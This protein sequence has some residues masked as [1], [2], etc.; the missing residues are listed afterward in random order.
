MESKVILNERGV[1]LNN[2][3][4]SILNNAIHKDLADSLIKAFD[5]EISKKLSDN[6]VSL[7]SFDDYLRTN[8]DYVLSEKEVEDMKNKSVI[9]LYDKE[10]MD[11]GYEKFLL[12]YDNKKD[13]ILI[14]RIIRLNVSY[15]ENF[16]GIERL[17]NKGDYK[18][19]FIPLKTLKLDERLN[20]FFKTFVEGRLKKISNEIE[21]EIKNGKKAFLKSN[22]KGVTFSNSFKEEENRI[23]ITLTIDRKSLKSISGHINRMG[24]FLEICNEV[25]ERFI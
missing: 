25:E 14:K 4:L 21:N 16:F 12:F 22:S 8:K 15:Y 7:S 1:A 19:S 2:L 23:D 3:K 11:K 10:L 6:T 5:L 17:K 13:C 18:N 9:E 24:T 20:I